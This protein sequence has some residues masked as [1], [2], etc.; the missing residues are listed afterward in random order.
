M[1]LNLSKILNSLG[2]KEEF[3]E[4]AVNAINTAK[5][6]TKEAD[7]I[8]SSQE[9][10]VEHYTKEILGNNEKNATISVDDFFE[11]A[12]KQGLLEESELA[13]F[14]AIIDR[15]G[16]EKFSHEEITELLSTA[17]KAYEDSLNAA[18]AQENEPTPGSTSKPAD[19]IKPESPTPTIKPT[20]EPTISPTKEPITEPEPT[21]P[22]TEPTISPTKEPTLPTQPTLPT[23]D[24]T[25]PTIPEEPEIDPA[26]DEATKPANTK[27]PNIN[28]TLPTEPTA[29]Q[30]PDP[31]IEPTKPTKLPYDIPDSYNE[32]ESKSSI[33]DFFRKFFNIE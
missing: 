9:N 22:T 32:T 1:D 17:Y 23:P 19:I 31:T 27:K 10:F 12:T 15:N 6:N 8:F 24:T 3:D 4:K 21:P 25:P 16:D 26:P 2:K 29:I 30:T 13:G 7:S 11:S 14:Q 20:T 33:L 28:P 5:E 18:K